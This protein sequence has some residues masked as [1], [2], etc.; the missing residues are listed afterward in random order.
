MKIFFSYRG[1]LHF[2]GLDVYLSVVFGT[3]VLWISGS[4]MRRVLDPH[5]T[6][7]HLCLK[8]YHSSPVPSHPSWWLI[9]SNSLSPFALSFT[10]YFNLATR[11][12][13]RSFLPLSTPG[14]TIIHPSGL[15]FGTS[16]SRKHPDPLD[17][18]RY[19]IWAS[20]VPGLPHPSPPP[21]PHHLGPD[22]SGS[23]LSGWI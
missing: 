6:T 18:I 2:P 23:S 22:H 5:V 8:S 19:V 9:G 16:S 20:I 1:S 21:M 14:F 12:F 4:Q 7:S 13:W 11:N 17:W 3:D 10:H 15:S